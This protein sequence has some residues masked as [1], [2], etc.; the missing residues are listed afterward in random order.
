M[1]DVFLTF[2]DLAT[3]EIVNGQHRSVGVTISSGNPKTPPMIFD[4][5][6]P[7]G[8]DFDLETSNLGN[9]L[10]LSEDGDGSDPDDN[11]GGGTLIF[12]FDAST[13]VQ[14]FT[15]LDVES[16]NSYANLYAEDG[17][18]LGTVHIP[19]TGNNGQETVWLTDPDT[20]KPFEGVARLEITLAE[21]GAIDNLSFTTPDLV[22]D[23]VLEGS[24]DDDLTDIDYTGDP[25]GDRIDNLDAILDGESGN[26]DI[27]DA[28]GGD[29][30]VR[31]GAGNDEVYAGSGDDVV[32]GNAG[33]D[34]IYGDS[35]YG[36]P[37]ARTTVR[38][39]LNWAQEG[40]GNNEEFGDFIQNT[41]SV[42]VSFTVVREDGNAQTE[43]ESH[44]QRVVG[45]RSGAET[46][47]E[48]SSLYSVINGDAG[49][50]EYRLEFSQVV[51]NV[52]FRVNDVDG[53]GFVRIRAF[54]AD[55]N[56]IALDLQGGSAVSVD[57]TQG[58]IDSQ[59][60][61][62]DDTSA[63]YSTLVSIAGPVARIDILHD[64]T[65]P[66][67]TGIN[68]TDVFFDVPVVDDGAPGDDRL[69]GGSGNDQI[70]GEA[71]DDLLRGGSG[72]DVLTGG[73][74]ED[75]M[76]GGADDD[77]FIVSSAEDGSGDVV[78]GST[79]GTDFDTLDLTGSG[80]LRIVNQTLDEDGDSTS[81]LVE[82]LDGVSG[83]VIGTLTFTEIENIV[84]CFT[85]GTSIAT[86]RGEFLVEDLQVGDTVITRD[87]G[88]QEIRWIGAKR[89][90]GRMLMQN[91][92][93]MPILVKQGSLGHG[94]PER[95]M[96]VS[97]N[98]R[99]LVNN[100]RVPLYF[101]DTEV[102]VSAKH[103]V[104]PRE[105]VQSI[106]SVGVTYIHFMFDRHEVVLSNGAWTES[107]QPGDYSL[108][109]IGN[110]QRNEIFELF[111]E[112]Q[113]KKGREAYASARL[114]LKKYEA[115]MLFD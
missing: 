80:P 7:T 34:V 77:T 99:M 61:Y 67:N 97:P 16:S 26:D 66:D 41:G 13:S 112:L 110:A 82:F 87:N 109:G 40:V 44:D 18:L 21:S 35:N 11:A 78:N 30:I 70:F 72:D 33:D 95:D 102:L 54:D 43:F 10:I 103:L 105:G 23:G 3:G 28:L 20:G 24:N 2:D 50:A 46:V 9:V 55:G 89:M 90:D 60:G 27:V 38:E 113:G 93:L 69:F 36:G 64:Q 65:G 73:A 56:E 57:P 107:F 59:G 51:E 52:S 1:P 42:D 63:A 31:A 25:E 85:P 114:T 92:H 96:L 6:E 91:P 100:D 115:R 22:G 74:G 108:R 53:D 71:G 47:D 48:N 76:I 15:V 84:P 32:R 98:H 45:I 37:G 14:S 58:T 29:D 101:D 94:L 79:G 19:T 4:T 68:V 17:A 12:E 75:R 88:I 5:S 111:P 39:S 8:N 81:G 106:Q 86:P 104:N 62:A 83:D 49:S